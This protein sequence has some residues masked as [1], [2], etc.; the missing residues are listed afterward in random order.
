[1]LAIEVCCPSE[2]CAPRE[3]REPVFARVGV[4]ELWYVDEPSRTLEVRRRT[5]GGYA[6]VRVFQGDALVSS[7][8]LPGLEFPLPAAWEDLTP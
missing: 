8:V 6:T 1:L 7:R 3:A 4:E 5:D 2:L